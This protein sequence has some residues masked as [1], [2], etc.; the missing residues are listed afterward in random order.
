MDKS[1]DHHSSACFRLLLVGSHCA[2]SCAFV[3]NCFEIIDYSSFSS[4]TY[5]TTN[6]VDEPDQ[7]PNSLTAQDDYK[8][9]IAAYSYADNF[10]NL[11][12]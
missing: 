2:T 11:S 6:L 8:Q 4:D 5:C 9:V 1:E 7:S 3:I 12:C 10:T